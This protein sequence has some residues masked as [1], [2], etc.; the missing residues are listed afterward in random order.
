M[1]IKQSRLRKPWFKLWMGGITLTIL[2]LVPLGMVM[3][4]VGF[5]PLGMA[6]I[7][8][9]SILLLMSLLVWGE[10]TAL[11]TCKVFDALILEEQ[12]PGQTET[13]NRKNE[14]T[15]WQDVILWM[16]S[17][18]GLEMLRLLKRVFRPKKADKLDWLD[19]SYLMLPVISLED[20]SLANAIERIR[21]LVRDHRLR[22]HPSLVGI[23]PI[24]GL[25]QWFLVLGG[26]ALG[27]WSG[28]TMADPSTANILSHL[29]AAALGTLLAGILAILGIFF[30][31]Y[32]RACYYTT[33]YHWALSVETARESDNPSQGKPPAIL[34]HVMRKTTLSKKD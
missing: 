22:F 18:P 21:Q 13:E 25:T 12:D 29:L 23:R 27:I 3:I 16:F 19:A 15:R 24:A 8:L 28:L 2:W 32:I 7:G 34:G 5:D 14:F 1:A 33:L 20:H 10:I 31:S 30:S 9:I 17:Q 11:E 4:L 26:G 6:L